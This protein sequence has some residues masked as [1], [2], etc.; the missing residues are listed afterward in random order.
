MA[1]REQTGLKIRIPRDLPNLPEVFRKR[2]AL[3]SQPVSAPATGTDGSVVSRNG[4]ESVKR[5]YSAM[6]LG[7]SNESADYVSYALET[8]GFKIKIMRREPSVT[9]S[10]PLHLAGAKNLAIRTVQQPASSLPIASN[11]S[12]VLTT[13]EKLGTVVASPSHPTVKATIR[14]NRSLSDSKA[15]SPGSTSTPAQVPSP[16]RSVIETSSGAPLATVSSRKGTTATGG[17]SADVAAK[18]TT[19][20]GGDASGSAPDAFGTQVDSAEHSPLLGSSSS[21][22]FSASDSSLESLSP[23]ELVRIGMGILD[24]LLGN[25]F[26]KSFINKV[27]LSVTN[28]H[29]VIKKPMDI[30]TAEQK[31]WKTLELAGEDSGAPAALM[32]AV[33]SLAKD[34]SEGYSNLAEFERDLRRICQNATYFNSPTHVIYKE[35]QVF[36]T[37]YVELL[38]NYRQG[39]LYLFRAHTP[40]EME[41]K[42][43]DI[44]TDL[45]ANF[46]QPIFDLSANHVGELSPEQPRFVRMY[47]NKNRSILAKSRDEQFARIAII[48]D[49]QIGKPYPAPI[50][51]PDS[52]SGSNSS[53]G[54]R[55]KPG[56]GTN[57]GNISM[58]HMS[59]K[60]LIGKPIGERHDMITVGD[61]DCPNAWITVACVRALDLEVEIPAKFE[62]GTLSKMRHEVVAYSSESKIAP[63]YQRHFAAAL[64]LLLPGSVRTAQAHSVIGQRSAIPLVSQPPAPQV[65]TS[66]P[67]RGSRLSSTTTPISQPT[68]HTPSSGLTAAGS[69]GS[70]DNNAVGQQSSK[71]T[72]VDLHD[73]GPDGPLMVKLRIPNFLKT[74]LQPAASLTSTTASSPS[75]PSNP[76]RVHVLSSQ[77]PAT[78]IPSDQESESALSQLVLSEQIT[79]RGHEMLLDLKVAAKEK[80]VPYARWSDIE[81]TLTVDTAHGL[82]KR[83]YH[84]RGQE[85]LVVQNFKEMDAESFDQRV[86]EVACLLKLRGLEGVGQ[87][88]SI[89]DNEDDHLVGLSM[90]KYPFTLKQYATNARRHPTPCQ[91]LCLVRDMVTAMCAIHGAGLAH[92]DLSEVNIMVDEDPNDL[93]EDQSPRPFVKVIDFG[94]SV[95]VE[96]GQVQRWSMQE[97]I[98]ED[99]LAMLPLV[100]LPPDHGYKLYRSILTLPKN[101]H[102]HTPLPPVDPRSEDVYSL[103][104]LIWRTFSGKSPWNGAIEDDLKTIRYLVSSDSQ[105]KFQLE[106]EIVGPVSRELLLR[107]LTAKAETRWTTQQLKDWLDQP[108]V[109]AELLKEFEALGGGRKKVRKNLD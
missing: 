95:F 91:K 98:S 7:D 39:S 75:T 13:K 107:C 83:I 66:T 36:Q 80:N 31:L 9:G 34:V 20:G 54:T 102:D 23:I 5:T 18:D 44:S 99:E 72:W 19:A 21:A 82:F 89:I 104:V 6:M 43:T 22:V 14:N 74:S 1:S 92:R 3:R 70:G 109:A 42:M 25:T 86:R 73:H 33:K 26:L 27:P 84:V 37:A 24:G 67:V 85:D 105:I 52:L 90:T 87:I 65:N 50:L 8:E 11:G 15:S 76:A 48:S 53:P 4:P 97:H 103:G 57:V 2:G 100:V 59:A 69:R 29:T 62:K 88:Q 16:P 40:R 51:S 96:R 63:E 12:A 41:R 10:I 45:F 17:R 35:A 81:P 93:L 38:N 77:V 32:D 47:I 55:S 94:K 64:G 78:S 101:K 79:K 106:R 56:A 58:V 108:E 71:T 30:V 68:Q 46:H 49:L 28:Y 60:V 61:L